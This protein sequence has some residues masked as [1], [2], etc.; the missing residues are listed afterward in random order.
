MG[1]SSV[2]AQTAAALGLLMEELADASQEQAAALKAR[3]LSRSVWFKTH[4]RK[5]R[6]V[7]PVPLQEVTYL[8]QGHL[9][10]SNS[11]GFRNCALGGW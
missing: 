9:Q 7:C 6:F 4:T 2:V 3:E 5:G 10:Q 8:R 1:R 11:Y